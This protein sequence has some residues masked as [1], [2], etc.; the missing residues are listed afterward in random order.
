MQII[1]LV[2]PWSTSRVE[3]KMQDKKFWMVS[4][5]L[6]VNSLEFT[7][8]D[9]KCN[10]P[11]PSLNSARGK[12][13]ARIWDFIWMWSELDYTTTHCHLRHSFRRWLTA[14][15]RL[16][17]GYFHLVSGRLWQEDILSVRGGSLSDKTPSWFKEPVQPKQ[18]A[19]PFQSDPFYALI[20]H[21]KWTNEHQISRSH[22]WKLENWM[23]AP[24]FLLASSN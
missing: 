23:N 17:C 22:A 14:I 3:F 21:P 16:S 9:P 5:D 8:P 13:A 6:H 4:E 24:G 12:Q 1:H 18:L 11:H 15:R 7:E 2:H 20:H 10:Q 19:S